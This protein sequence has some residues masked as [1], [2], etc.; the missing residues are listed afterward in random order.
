MTEELE[1]LYF[2]HVKSLFSSLESAL[3]YA[4]RLIDPKTSN[5]IKYMEQIANG[6]DS[7]LCDLENLNSQLYIGDSDVS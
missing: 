1:A 6:I 7:A 5:K 4:N 3:M 2:V